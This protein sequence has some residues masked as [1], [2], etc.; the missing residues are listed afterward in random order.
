[1]GQLD[2]Q[3]ARL[4]LRDPAAD[5][6]SLAIRLAQVKI[7]INQ[8]CKRSNQTMDEDREY[9]HTITL[10]VLS[11]DSRPQLVLRRMLE[12]IGRGTYF[13]SIDAAEARCEENAEEAEIA[14]PAAVEREAYVALL[15]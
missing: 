4:A 13:D 9:S 5:P 2:G 6:R 7:L 12:A 1:M 15:D 3:G 14:D 8:P 10:R 11:R